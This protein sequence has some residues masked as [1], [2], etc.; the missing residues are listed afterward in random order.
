[1]NKIIGI[2]LLLLIFV[3]TVATGQNG[4]IEATNGIT[5]GDN[6][7][8]ITDGTIRYDGTDFWGLN[9]GMWRSLTGLQTLTDLSD[10]GSTV[11]LGISGVMGNVNLTNAIR[12]LPGIESNWANNSSNI[13]YDSGN[14]GVGLN[15]PA[16]ILDINGDFTL[17][18]SLRRIDFRLPGSTTSLGGMTLSGS[19]LFV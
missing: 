1:M 6:L 13:F 19:N 9:N 15:N 14:V 8:S 3:Q 17:R 16:T 18:G 11:Q 10:P 4:T 12:S 7:T 2:L 5:I